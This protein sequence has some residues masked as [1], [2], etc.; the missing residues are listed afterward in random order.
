M[1]TLTIDFETMTDA[2]RCIRAL[3]KLKSTLSVGEPSHYY[4]EGRV[5]REVSFTLET[6]K[7]AEQF[8]A[9]AYRVA[10]AVGFIGVTEQ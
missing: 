4:F 6:T 10:S 2:K 9:W 3:N 7:T 1:H 8:D 5:Q